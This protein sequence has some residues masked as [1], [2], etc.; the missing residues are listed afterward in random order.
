MV[1][2]PQPR[3]DVVGTVRGDERRSIP[4]SRSGSRATTTPTSGSA[5]GAT[6][7]PSQPSCTTLSGTAR[8]MISPVATR[9]PASRASPSVAPGAHVYSRRASERAATVSTPVTSPG[10]QST[11]MICTSPASESRTERSVARSAAPE[12]PAVTMTLSVSGGRSSISPLACRLEPRSCSVS[13]SAHAAAST[14]NPACGDHRCADSMSCAATV[15]TA[16][17]VPMIRPS[18]APAAS[19][20]SQPTSAVPGASRTMVR[21]RTRTTGP[22]RPARTT[23]GVT[24]QEASATATTGVDGRLRAGVGRTAPASSSLRAPRRMRAGRAV[25]SRDGASPGSRAVPRRKEMS[26]GATAIAS[27]AVGDD[28]RQADALAPEPRAEQERQRQQ[29]REQRPLEGHDPAALAAQPHDRDEEEDRR[30]ERPGEEQE[31][32]DRRALADVVRAERPQQHRRGDRGE[33]REQRERAE[34]PADEPTG[35]LAHRTLVVGAL[36]GERRR[37][38]Q[39]QQVEGHRERERDGEVRVLRAAQQADDEQ[40]QAQQ[41]RLPED[42]PR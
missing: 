35:E 19:G 23:A 3:D 40:R 18:P 13:G 32:Q 8:T 37:A 2:G 28:P 36:D 26:Q 22:V 11:T 39:E 7:E 21:T 38:V 14:Q 12:C 9:R 1:A 4:A 25:T 34:Q 6:I 30:A 31:P 15:A 17:L 42:R 41:R 33:D 5:N 27:E 29:H 20:R 16:R 10:S 24:T